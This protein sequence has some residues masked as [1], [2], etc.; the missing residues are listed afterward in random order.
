MLFIIHPE[1]EVEIFEGAVYYESEQSGL[2]IEFLSAIA[3]A[4]A[5]ISQ[6]PAAWSEVDRGIRKFVMK[7]FPYNIY[8]STNKERTIIIAVAHQKRR[9]GYWK[10]RLQHI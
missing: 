7:E 3:K 1:A 2:G 9:P 8:Y 4:K 5:N 10:F 6:L